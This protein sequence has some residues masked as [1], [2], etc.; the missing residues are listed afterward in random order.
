MN[1][2]W[3]R[4]KKLTE[5][6][7]KI[8]WANLV[9]PDTEILE[10]KDDITAGD[11][12]KHDI[13][14]G[15]AMVDWKTNRDILELLKRYGISMA[16]IGSPA[17]RI[18]IVRKLTKILKLEVVMRRIATGSILDLLAGRIKEGD[19]FTPPLMQFFYKDDFLHDPLLEPNFLLTIER[20]KPGMDLFSQIAMLK[21][22]QFL[23]L[24]AAFAQFGIQYMDDKIEIGAVLNDRDARGELCWGSNGE[25]MLVDEITA[26]SF[27]AWP[28][29]DGVQQIDLTVENAMS[30]LNKGGMLDK[31]LYR[32]GAETSVV[33]EKFEQIAEITA[34]FAKLDIRVDVPNVSLARLLGVA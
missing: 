26:G 30:Q 17:E 34:T 15:K 5:G 7:T 14:E 20:K 27:R 24:E 16:Y 33:K 11:G 12:L 19:V 6:K 23:V 28:Y 1:L 4:G 13:I 29:A 31:Q 32:D 9:N 3:E 18:V 8:V 10:F 22:R 21:L 25:I 2:D